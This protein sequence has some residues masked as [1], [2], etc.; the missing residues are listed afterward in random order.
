MRPPALRVLLLSP[1]L[2]TGGNAA[3]ARRLAEA[4][5]AEGAAVRTLATLDAGF[6]DRLGRALRSFRPDVVHALHARKGGAAYL[7]HA[8]PGD[9]PLVITLTGTEIHRDLA[10]PGRSR[11]TLAALAAAR[12]VLSHGR[13]L[14]AAALAAVP[15]LEGR[16]AIVP[17]GVVLPPMDRRFDLRRRAGFPRDAVVFLLPAGLREVK[18]PLFS[19][20]PLARLRAD[21]RRVCFVHA[22]ETIEPALRAEFRRRARREPWV[23]TVGSLAASRMGSAYA[24]A[25][26]VL[27]TSRSEGLSNAVVEAQAAGRAV[28][29]SDIPANRELVSHGRTGLLYRAGDEDSFLRQARRLARDPALR[30]RLGTAARTS[31]ARRFSSVAEARAVLAAYR[32][33]LG[34]APRRTPTKVP[35]VP[36]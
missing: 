26:V 10:D 19:L 15:S 31:V 24:G 20:G 18:D 13:S 27:N 9:P 25:D 17:K 29:V 28:L 22:G 12:I 7:R 1:S 11:E 35:R 33:A 30:A 32:G 16:A 21:D 14:L 3:T 4:L 2:A 5:R 34:A 36:L 8:L 23:R 6:P